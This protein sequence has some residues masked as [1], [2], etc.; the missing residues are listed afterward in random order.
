MKR[1]MRYGAI[2]FPLVPFLLL[3]N[4]GLAHASFTVEDERKLGKEFYETLEKSGA[5][6]KEPRIN[7]YVNAV[8]M[9][10]VA[11]GSKS[12]F[13]F[14]FSVIKSSA[15]NAFATP[16][17]Y[18]YVNSGLITI[19]ENES[20]LA[21][22][23]AHETGHVKAR[24]VAQMIEQSTKISIATLA[25]IIAGAVFG[26][27]G[28]LTAA[29]TGFSMAGASSLSL[30]YSRDHEE[31]ADRLGMTYLTGA[32]YDGRT[33][34]EFLR[35]MRQYEFYASNVPSYFFTHPGTEERI[36]YLEALI[37][38]GH[39]PE[40][41]T[42]II[43]N[44]KRIQTMLFVRGA[45]SAS[46]LNHFQNNL[47]KNPDDVDDLYGLALT[48]EKLGSIAESQEIFQQAL[49]RSPDDANILRDLGVS[50]FK[51]GKTDSAIFYLDRAFRIDGDDEDTLLY[52][53]RAY[54]AAGQYKS[55]LDL[56]R[57]AEKKNIDDADIYYNLAMAYGKMDNPGDS[58]YNFGIYFKK[59]NKLE[60][61]LFHFQA[62]LT[63]FPKESER[64]KDI[65]KE[66]E[67]LKKGNHPRPSAERPIPSGRKR[68]KS[69]P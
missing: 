16:G 43:G 5:L 29:V 53:G 57:R 12:P 27:G 44:F 45:D 1:F 25:A 21:A 55:A 13:E 20:Q 54:I 9:R 22:V 48:Q 40:G 28:D 2:L 61:A 34:P 66:I 35:I 36:Q 26:R 67:S 18:V 14:R 30:K 68:G 60:S 51:S 50:Y 64:A 38:T 52:L 49:K 39:I 63:F 58:H 46:S 37:E 33:M 65:N 6:I 59:K 7:D 41:V 8:G 23:I 3:V 15:I 4:F 47:K 17:G 62:A 11:Q 69:A 31:E 19:M 10:I 32:G 56:F 42:S 24:H